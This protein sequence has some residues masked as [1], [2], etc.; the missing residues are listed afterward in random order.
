MS[1]L[2]INKFANAQKDIKF[3]TK[4]MKDFIALGEYVEGVS[5]LSGQVNALVAKKKNLDEEVASLEEC[6]VEGDT[7]IQAAT[8]TASDIVKRAEK[9]AEDMV[10]SA[11][12]EN[13]AAR[14]KIKQ[15][16]Q[17]LNNKVEALMK[18]AEDK[19]NLKEIEVSELSRAI[20]VKEKELSDLNRAIEN[21]KGKFV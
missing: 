17:D 21:I 14:E 9:Q 6:R 4:H 10:T 3:F 18:E 16:T 5:K 19:A 13:A 1:D 11:A 15:E 12:S 8:D 2:D 7:I 20:S